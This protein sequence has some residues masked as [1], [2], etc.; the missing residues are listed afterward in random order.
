MKFHSHH[1][2]YKRSDKHQE[3]KRNKTQ[4]G[5]ENNTYDTKQPASSNGHKQAHD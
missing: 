4:K 2:E 5:K 3:N 1:W